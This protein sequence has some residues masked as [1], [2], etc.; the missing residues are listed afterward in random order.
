MSPHMEDPSALWGSERDQ[1]PQL[2]PMGKSSLTSST[3]ALQSIDCTLFILENSSMKVSL[4]G[5]LLPLHFLSL[6]S[7]VPDLLV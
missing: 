5:S 7:V 4:W 1:P 2:N 3:S 6:T